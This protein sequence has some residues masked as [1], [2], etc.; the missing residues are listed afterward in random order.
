VSYHAITPFHVVAGILALLFGYTALFAAK[1]GA[2]HR[3]A[4]KY[5]VYAMVV[6]SLTGA[7]MGMFSGVLPNVVAGLLTFYFVATGLLA[8]RRTSNRALDLGGLL[9]VIAVGLFAF[10]SGRDAAGSMVAPPLF[11]FGSVAMLAAVGDAKLLSAGRLTGSSRLK[12]H[13]WRLC[14]AMWIAAASF[15]WGP[16]GRVPEII[17]IPALLPIPV[18]TPIGVM[19][20]WLWRLRRKRAAETISAMPMSA[21][22]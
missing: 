17:N 21:S 1:G 11:L 9:I 15:F 6:M 7:V 22:R 5:F 14:F 2:T 19:L 10:K 20:Y 4:G 16:K 8:V 3:R 13:L 12:R 18:L